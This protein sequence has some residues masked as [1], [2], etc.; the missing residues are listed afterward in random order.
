MTPVDYWPKDRR[1]PD[2]QYR[3]ILSEIKSDGEVTGSAHD[4]MSKAVFDKVMRFDLRNGVPMITERDFTINARS[5]IG[6]IL[7]FINGV[8]TLEGLRKFGVSDRL[9]DRWVTEKKCA[10]R[11]LVAGD[12][13][14]GSYGPS[15]HDFPTPDGPFNQIQH[16]VE[17]IKELP[18]LRSH[19]VINWIPQYQGRGKDK[20]QKVVVTPCHG[21]MFWRVIGDR[22]DLHMVQHKADMIAGVP[23]N[24][25]QYAALHLAMAHVT[26]KTA[27]NYSHILID[28]HIYFHNKMEDDDGSV[29]TQEEAV[30]AML[31]RNPKKFPIM[32][33]APDAPGNI[34]DFRTE[35]FIITEYE[36]HPSIK[37]ITTAI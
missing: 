24:M 21:D 16:V 17:Q 30:D 9:W 1:I 22:L 2:G 35:H 36:P 8:H 11:G 20:Q 34:F 32:H 13:G 6:E 25:I 10:K 23:S 3:S 18:E 4:E 33:L 31:H 27:G 26:G 19:R 15:F 12:L 37:G 14:P 28:A 29:V 7:A 5:A